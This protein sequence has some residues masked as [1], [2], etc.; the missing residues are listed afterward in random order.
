MEG[1]NVT[2]PPLMATLDA[3]VDGSSDLRYAQTV[4]K[5]VKTN[6]KKKAGRKV[7]KKKATPH[8][9]TPLHMEENYPQPESQYISNS[10]DNLREQYHLR[11]YSASE[12]EDY[13]FGSMSL[14][15][16]PP[17]Q[18]D[19]AQRK[20]HISSPPLTDRKAGQK[21]AFAPKSPARVLVQ[22]PTGGAYAHA[23]AVHLSPT[24]VSVQFDA[25]P[26]HL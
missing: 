26:L 7:G 24:D 15:S 14:E 16:A 5:V 2:F 20:V 11:R 6:G 17:R 25:R 19:E 12:R 4:E 10:V 3:Y 22:S 8:N 9:L 23:G 21:G 13:I 1:P 18:S